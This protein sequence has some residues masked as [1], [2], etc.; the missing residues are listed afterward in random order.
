[1]LRSHENEELVSEV[2]TAVLSWMT[3]LESCRALAATQKRGCVCGEAGRGLSLSSP[4]SS[5]R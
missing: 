5:P 4:L 2:P 3:E 1:M